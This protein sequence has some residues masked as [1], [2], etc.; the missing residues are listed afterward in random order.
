MPQNVTERFI[1]KKCHFDIIR[2]IVMMKKE[3]LLI[4]L[5]FNADISINVF[6]YELNGCSPQGVGLKPFSDL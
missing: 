2:I 4:S 5:T 3:K 6:T 1:R